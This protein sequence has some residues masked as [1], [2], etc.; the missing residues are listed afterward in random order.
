MKNFATE[1]HQATVDPCALLW[2]KVLEEAI[3][4]AQAGNLSAQ[5]FFKQGQESL[6]Q[7]ICRDLDLPADKLAR[8]ALTVRRERQSRHRGFGLGGRKAKAAPA[9]TS[10]GTWTTDISALSA[11]TQRTPQQ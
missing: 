7:K 3:C 4:S 11:W 2:C 9:V 6:F 8:A 5:M 10:L 1:R